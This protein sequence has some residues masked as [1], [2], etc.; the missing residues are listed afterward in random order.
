MPRVKPCIHL[1]KAIDGPGRHAWR[2]CNAGLGSVYH[3]G[4][5]QRCK[6]YLDSDGGN[7]KPIIQKTLNIKSKQKGECVYLGEEVKRWGSTKTWRKCNR[8]HGEEGGLVCMCLSEVFPKS[9]NGCPDK[10]LRLSIPEVPNPPSFFKRLD[11]TNL[12]PDSPGIRFNASVTLFE[13]QRYIV[14]RDATRYS[15][16]WIGRLDESYSGVGTT[17][18]L[19]DIPHPDAASSKEDPRFFVWRGKLYIS[20]VGVVVSKTPGKKNELDTVCSLLYARINP[21]TLQAIECYSPYY[22]NRNKLEKNWSFFEG[23]DTNLYAVYSIA[24]HRVLRIEDDRAELVA[25]T[26]NVCPWHSGECRGG[27]APVLDKNTGNYLSLFHSRNQNSVYD[28]GAYTF[29]NRHPFRIQNWKRT[30]LLT[31]DNATLSASDCNYPVVFP[32]GAIIE[33]TTDTLL[34]SMGVHDRWIE[35]HRFPLREIYGGMEEVNPPSWF[36]SHGQDNEPGCFSSI[37]VWD[38]YGLDRLDLKGKTV[39]DIG[40]YVGYFAYR[41]AKLGATNIHCYEPQPESFAILK[42]NAKRMPQVRV[43]NDAIGPHSGRL[44]NVPCGNEL[45]SNQVR[46]D[47][48]GTVIAVTLED[49]IIRACGELDRVGCLKM[50]IEGF[51]WLVLGNS[52]DLS[53][54]DSICGEYHEQLSIQPDNFLAVW[55]HEKLKRRLV[56]AGFNEVVVREPGPNGVGIF[57]ARRVDVQIKEE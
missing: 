8:G 37:K 39:L 12:F 14:Y 46:Y 20:F 51:E 19:L 36:K 7:G 42:E 32:C 25:D 17:A 18:N 16:L 22:P 29:S 28:I 38:E 49:A 4:A 6:E 43:Y 31:A 3:S 40:A 26:P 23:E 11:E 34:V 5:C 54:V 13:G 9:C 24:P 33:S 41:C 52:I 10:K 27:A 50:D 30:R 53:R 1:G 44:E 56:E 21:T 55:S 2:E 45:T 48:W 57:H 15:N 47:S 35:L